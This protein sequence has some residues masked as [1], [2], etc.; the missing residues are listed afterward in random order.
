MGRIVDFFAVD[1]PPL[2]E[3]LRLSLADVFRYILE[4]GSEESYLRYVVG[5]NIYHVSPRKGME[6]S[7]RTNA[8]GLQWIPLS[9]PQLD[10]DLQLAISCQEYLAQ[11]DP[12]CLRELL[13]SLGECPSVN[14]VE[15]LY[16][17]K[18]FWWPID[19]LF[20]W[21]ESSQALRADEYAQYKHLFKKVLR[22]S[23]VRRLTTGPQI[24]LSDLSFP[25][26]PRWDP[27]E[28]MGAWTAEEIELFALYTHF[29]LG[30][31]PH[32][33]S[34]PAAEGP[35]DAGR[36]TLNDWVHEVLESLLKVETLGF[37][38]PN[39]VSFVTY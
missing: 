12:F 11:E 31:E 1:I 15:F 24:E 22:V 37:G 2:E 21:I 33:G 9:A 17:C 25:V 5:S 28:F 18:R 8:G 29:L 36:D 23:T 19:S 26:I 38:V 32:F 27:N 10:A 20:D 16:W 39:I 14:W 6:R 35:V 3:F 13:R 7:Q 4:N 34:D 30:L